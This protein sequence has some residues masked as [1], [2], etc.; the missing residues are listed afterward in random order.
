ME[1]KSASR[2][3]KINGK[4]Y[5]L[6]KSYD[7]KYDAQEVAARLRK[8]GRSARIIERYVAVNPYSLYV[9]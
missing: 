6:Q 8:K 4:V 1:K 2:T 7:S 3:K 5:R 9:R